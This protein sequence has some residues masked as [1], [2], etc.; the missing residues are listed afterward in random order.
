MI[1]I[2]TFLLFIDNTA[3]LVEF[4]YPEGDNPTEPVFSVAGK[5]TDLVGL[6]SLSWKCNNESGEFE[7]TPEIIIG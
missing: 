7:L 1:G 3:P 5:A 6:S 2:H 4:I